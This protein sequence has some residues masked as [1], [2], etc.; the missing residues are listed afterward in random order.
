MKGSLAGPVPGTSSK[1]ATRTSCKPLEGAQT[2]PSLTT[3]EAAASTTDLRWTKGE[4][5]ICILADPRLSI[6]PSRGL[7]PLDSDRRKRSRHPPRLP[8]AVRD[9]KSSNGP[10]PARAGPSPRFSSR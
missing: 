4:P 2:L 8:A 6:V 1:A 7:G 10:A 3:I 9:S 5:L